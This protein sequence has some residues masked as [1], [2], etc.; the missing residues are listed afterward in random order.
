MLYLSIRDMSTTFLQI[1]LCVTIFILGA[2]VTIALQHLYSHFW[3]HEQPQDDA[4]TQKPRATA[5][6]APV[7]HLPPAAKERLL[8]E[9]EAR[10]QTVLEHT[11]ADL[12]KDLQTTSTQL[13][14]SLEKLGH[15][16]VTAEM[17][18]FRDT[19]EQLRQQSEQT[20][21]GAQSD[22]DSGRDALEA[23]LEKQRAE[24][25]A[26]LQQDIAA[27][28][29]RL[30]DELLAEQQQLARQI[31]SQLGDAVASFLLDTL[32]HDVDLGAQNAYLIKMLDAHKDEFKQ[33]LHI[34][35]AHA[36]SKAGS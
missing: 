10:F 27:E 30:A 8:H 11:A 35:A 9:S 31:D 36:K 14:R 12:E 2:V 16:I 32:Q 13:N 29:E 18:R 24:L 20:L 26:R 33:A 21:A 6:T 4:R 23:E 15:D 34:D 28:R 19:L 17:T 7:G 22:I 25:T 5:T 3:P 1:F